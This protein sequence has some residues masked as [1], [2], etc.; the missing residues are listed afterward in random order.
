MI[1][2]IA[3]I[4]MI[5]ALALGV[6]AVAGILYPFGLAS[7]DWQSP[8]ASFA[9]GLKGRLDRAAVPFDN[10]TN[11]V[12]TWTAPYWILYAI[13]LYMLVATVVFCSWF[14]AAAETRPRRLKRVAISLFWII[15]IP[16]LLV[17][18]W[19]DSGEGGNNKTPVRAA[20]TYALALSVCYVGARLI[21]A[22]MTS[23]VDAD[24]YAMSDVGSAMTKDDRDCRAL[25]SRHERSRRFLQENFDKAVNGAQWGKAAKTGRV[26]SNVADCLIGELSYVDTA[27]I[28]FNMANAFY[29]GHQW[30]QSRWFFKNGF[31]AYTQTVDDLD[32]LYSSLDWN[33][34]VAVSARLDQS[35][36]F[37]TEVIF[38]Y[39]LRN[40]SS[41]RHLLEADQGPAL[42]ITDIYNQVENLENLRNRYWRDVIED[43][44]RPFLDW[45]N[46][47]ALVVIEALIDQLIIRTQS[48]TDRDIHL[49]AG[50]SLDWLLD[51]SR[52]YGWQAENG[53]YYQT[54]FS[55]HPEPL[56]NKWLDIEDNINA[57][58]AKR[59]T[60]GDHR[61]ATLQ[62]VISH[63]IIQEVILP[64]YADVTPDADP[65][66]REALGVGLLTAA[67]FIDAYEK[68]SFETPAD[69][70]NVN[71]EYGVSDSVVNYDRDNFI[72]DPYMTYYAIAEKSERVE[73]AAFVYRPGIAYSIRSFLASGMDEEQ[74]LL[75]FQYRVFYRGQFVLGYL[76]QGL[77]LSRAD[78]TN[79]L[80]DRSIPDPEGI[81]ERW[82]NLNDELCVEL[83]DAE[84][85]WDQK[86]CRDTVEDLLRQGLAA[87]ILLDR[88]S[89]TIIAAPAPL[90]EY[91]TVELMF[92][93][94][95]AYNPIS[96]SPETF[97]TRKDDPFGRGRRGAVTLRARADLLGPPL[98][99]DAF[100]KGVE[101]AN[102]FEYVG[103]PDVFGFGAKA[104][105]KFREVLKA[106]LQANAGE[107]DVLIYVHGVGNTFASA[108]KRTAQLAYDLSFPGEAMF[109]SW[110]TENNFLGYFKDIDV[111][112]AAIAD[113][114]NFIENAAQTA[115]SVCEDAPDC[116]PGKVHVIAHS[117]GARVT[118]DSL[119]KL[120]K[121]RDQAG[122]P[123]LELG[124]LIFAAPDVAGKRLKNAVRD[125]LAKSA[126]RVTV[127]TNN[128]DGALWL[129]SM[130]RFFKWRGGLG[131]SGQSCSADMIDSSNAVP[132]ASHGY[133]AKESEIIADIRTLIWH[134][135]MNPAQRCFLDP[136]EKNSGTPW[137]IAKNKCD[138]TGYD[139]GSQIAIQQKRGITPEREMEN[140]SA[141]D[142][143]FVSVA[144]VPGGAEFISHQDA[145]TR[146]LVSS[147]PEQDEWLLVSTSIDDGSQVLDRLDTDPHFAEAF[148]T[149]NKI[150]KS[151]G[152]P[153]LPRCTE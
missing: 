36:Q 15:T 140:S 90:P 121:E 58:Y 123:N 18:S 28:N 57:L 72:A 40:L 115:H 7:V 106:R 11:T 6:F 129:S 104:E 37:N 142:N 92:G 145:W 110:P 78:I 150:S 17:R 125:E 26:I 43:N 80:D 63:R 74:F 38:E 86:S 24:E 77:D 16:V 23:A 112:D 138:I 25:L 31:A 12:F 53:T 132:F 19:R 141:F 60:A 119:L 85:D 48:A 8:F 45:L 97:F 3:R 1:N 103:S 65:Q 113:L 51:E 27:R 20:L 70:L 42:T 89:V 99:A 127:Y 10:F 47:D 88:R 33:D 75:R 73:Q 21:N 114:A 87:E 124:Q 135:N 55:F 108:S 137:R 139:I 105:Q 79:R 146:Q 32:E 49:F 109:Y 84:I 133:F 126:D 35:V 116:A 62:Y 46:R 68:L 107:N 44:E 91:I 52:A 98:L 30:V 14:F 144:K 134:Q 153:A 128:S 82:A 4:W 111:P 94:T 152:D 143:F 118:V 50:R 71:T 5:A 148:S 95:R 96:L 59:A 130:L 56:Q 81:K 2:F 22:Q 149:F 100:A 69:L 34:N 76:N 61:L 136:K 122:K 13:V 93:T 64:I 67:R 120:A 83:A 117:H 102:L 54:Q 147:P 9:D 131:K 39:R 151:A 41:L 66:I 101:R 29:D